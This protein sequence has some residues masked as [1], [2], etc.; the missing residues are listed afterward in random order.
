[1]TFVKEISSAVAGVRWL[2]FRRSLNG[3]CR[4]IMQHPLVDLVNGLILCSKSLIGSSLLLV[5]FIFL[6]MYILNVW[7][8]EN[9]L[10]GRQNFI[11]SA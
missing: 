2:L 3:D 9:V 5:S 1:M 11:F 7:A 6:G 10:P 8:R 4:E